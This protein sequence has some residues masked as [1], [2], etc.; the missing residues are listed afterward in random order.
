MTQYSINIDYDQ[1]A[2]TKVDTPDIFFPN[3]SD[4]H[5]ESVVLAKQICAGCSEKLN[6]FDHG[7]RHERDGIWGGATAPERADY[8]R[9]F[10]IPLEPINYT[11]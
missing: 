5:I 8:R 10:H 2:C 4:S 9:E 1:A 11:H 3:G 6:C 7:I